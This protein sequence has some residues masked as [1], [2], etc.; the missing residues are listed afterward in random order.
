MWYT[1][2]LTACKWAIKPQ[3]YLK[4][5][6][7][8]S[9][10]DVLRKGHQRRSSNQNTKWHTRWGKRKVAEHRLEQLFHLC[11]GEMISCPR[12]IEGGVLRFLSAWTLMDTSSLQP[13]TYLRIVENRYQYGIENISNWEHFLRD[14]LFRVHLE[15]F[16]VVVGN[17]VTR[18]RSIKSRVGVNQ[19][20]II[21]IDW[22]SQLSLEA[23]PGI[24]MANQD[25]S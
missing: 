17:M 21:S 15:S 2:I 9:T 19:V 8:T 25:G 23:Y 6:R 24:E 10:R 3:S 14:N 20:L 7:H 12:Y 11:K 22:I 16:S 1:L 18:N 4:D 13:D 5:I